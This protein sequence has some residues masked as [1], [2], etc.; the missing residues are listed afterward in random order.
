MLP[1]WSV[2]FVAIVLPTPAHG[3]PDDEGGPHN[4]VGYFTAGVTLHCDR[5][6][7][8]SGVKWSHIAPGGTRERPVPGRHSYWGS[9][10]GRHGLRLEDLLRSD[11]GLYVC[12]SRA[13]VPQSF[14]PASAFVVVVADK[15]VCR[16]LALSLI[17][18]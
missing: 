13:D 9:S 16:V 14:S 10:Y 18:I 3:S 11:A 4:V 12:R 2:L 8:V 1:V 17:H 6:D 7:S 5:N 15:P